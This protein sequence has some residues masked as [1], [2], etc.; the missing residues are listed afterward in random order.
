MPF[1]ALGGSTGTGDSFSLI[2]KMLIKCFRTKNLH[3]AVILTFAHPPGGQKW[4]LHWFFFARRNNLLFITNLWYIW[5]VK[6]LVVVVVVAEVV[7]V[8]EVRKMPL[9]TSP[10]SVLRLP[11][12]L[13]HIC[14]GSS[15]S[16]HRILEKVW[17][18]FSGIVA[19][20]TA[21]PSLIVFFVYRLKAAC[22]QTPQF[23]FST[24]THT[25]NVQLA[26]RESLNSQESVLDSKW[27]TGPFIHKRGHKSDD[28]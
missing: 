5:E 27:P 28:I 21:L 2:G 7:V 10:R 14:L 13:S 4:L 16:I 9:P 19:Q 22:I 12:C 23:F 6:D 18:I 24:H 3:R 8:I 1:S 20:K 25:Q 15:M 17:K 11:V 26:N